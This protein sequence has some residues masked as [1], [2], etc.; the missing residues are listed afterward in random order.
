RSCLSL[1][2]SFLATLFLLAHIHHQKSPSHPDSAAPQASPAPALV[3]SQMLSPVAPDCPTM[4]GV[5]TTLP[6]SS[7][8]DKPTPAESKEPE[9]PPASAATSTG[10]SM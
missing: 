1:A 10:S 3:S 7:S 9:L 2:F 6:A 8:S 5:A 4:G